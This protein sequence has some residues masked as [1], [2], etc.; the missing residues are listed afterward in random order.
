[1]CVYS[2]HFNTHVQDVCTYLNQKRIYDD[3][4]V[5]MWGLE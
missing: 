4:C 3:M 2:S 5:F 1:M